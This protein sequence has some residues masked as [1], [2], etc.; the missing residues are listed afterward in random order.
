MVIVEDGKTCAQYAVS[1]EDYEREKDGAYAGYTIVSNEDGTPY[2]PPAEEPP[3]K[4]TPA[5]KKAS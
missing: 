4:A 3:A 2:E 1:V 5:K